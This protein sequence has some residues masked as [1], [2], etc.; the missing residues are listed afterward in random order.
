M[1]SRQQSLFSDYWGA[2]WFVSEL[3]VEQLTL[4]SIM[5][6]RLCVLWNWCNSS[7]FNVMMTWHRKAFRIAGPFF[8]FCEG[9]SPVTG[10]SPHLSVSTEKQRQDDCPVR[11]CIRRSLPSTSAVVNRAVILTTFQSVSVERRAWLLFCCQFEQSFQQT[12]AFVGYF[13]AL[14]NFPL[15]PHICVGKL[16]QHWFR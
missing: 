5:M 9:N 7:S 2:Q 6:H 12:M 16:G 11:H 1:S 15:V 10:D 13:D 8:L 14:T 4:L 3:H